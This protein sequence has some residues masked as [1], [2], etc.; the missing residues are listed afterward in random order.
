MSYDSEMRQANAPNW[1]VALAF[2]LVLVGLFGFAQPW[3][4]APS[5]SMTLNAFD[6]AEWTSLH[7]T[8][9]ATSPPMLTP[10]M[11]RLQLLILSV[12][13]G[14]LPTGSSARAC[15]AIMI[16]VLTLAQLPPLDIV[17]DPNNL[18]YRQQLY[19][20]A[21]SLTAS[22]CLFAV[23]RRRIALLA[24]IA[25]PIIGIATASYGLAE[26]AGLYQHF[27]IGQAPG[28]GIWI[29]GA[30]YIGIAA[31]AGALRHIRRR[32][33]I[34]RMRMSQRLRE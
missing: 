11:L 19:L 31:I 12:I 15:A 22:F 9:R 29:L 10:L 28:A 3:I 8:Q 25:L 26:A 33:R 7:P 6:L 5:G 2:G 34:N 18:N 23:N 30:S 21:A 20:A 24:S 27:E 13:L 14:A 17:Y 4:V 16:L 1:L 32:F